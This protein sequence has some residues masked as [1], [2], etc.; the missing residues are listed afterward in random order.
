MIKKYL[1]VLL[2]SLFFTIA[3]RGQTSEKVIKTQHTEIRK[4]KKHHTHRAVEADES[5][6]DKMKT[7]KHKSPARGEGGPAKR[8]Q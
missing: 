1:I 3:S 4:T 5:H 2:A 6:S 8:E 7:T